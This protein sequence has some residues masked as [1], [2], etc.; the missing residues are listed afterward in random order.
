[1]LEYISGLELT[2][3]GKYALTFLISLT[4]VLELRA[5]IPAGVLLGLPVLASAAVSVVGNILPVPFIILFIRRVLAWMRRRSPRLERLASALEKR[6]SSKR[7]ILYKGT[8]LGL[9]IFVAIPLP[10]TG[11]WTGAL[12]AAVLSIRLR[13]A[14]PAIFAGV[15]IAGVLVTGITFGFKSLL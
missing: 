9:L 4:P 7:E 3:L 13:V 11:A 8:V 10:G 5:A 6:A 12:I 14:L 1:M 2:E 15:V